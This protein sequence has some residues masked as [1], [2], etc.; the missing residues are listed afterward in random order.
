MEE[1]KKVGT[2]V[3]SR[4][5]VKDVKKRNFSGRKNSVKKY[6]KTDMKRKMRKDIKTNVN[7]RS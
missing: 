4:T 1:E 2:S 5:D 7:A 6:A 3:D